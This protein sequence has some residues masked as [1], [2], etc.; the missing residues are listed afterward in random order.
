[1]QERCLGIFSSAVASLQAVS[2]QYQYCSLSLKGKLA[3]VS[4][5]TSGSLAP[6]TPSRG[7][8]GR[9]EWIMEFQRTWFNTTAWIIDGCFVCVCVC[10]VMCCVLCDVSCQMLMWYLLSAP[11]LCLCVVCIFDYWRVD[12]M[13]QRYHHHPILIVFWWARERRGGGGAWHSWQ[14]CNDCRCC[15]DHISNYVFKFT[16]CYISILKCDIVEN[17]LRKG[18]LHMCPCL[19]VWCYLT[20]LET[21]AKDA[22]T[23][24]RRVAE[25]EAHWKLCTN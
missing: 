23:Q 1:M 11:L 20:N 3:W 19:T 25:C 15:W 5:L 18:F 13:I 4:R 9:G 10:H 14:R 24:L 16:N 8:Q 2:S 21:E 17:K 7:G 6:L 22:S 12:G